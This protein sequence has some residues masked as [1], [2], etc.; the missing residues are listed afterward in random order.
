MLKKHPKSRTDLSYLIQLSDRWQFQS[1]ESK[2]NRIKSAGKRFLGIPFKIV[3]NLLNSAHNKELFLIELLLINIDVFVEIAESVNELNYW[4]TDEEL[5]ELK[6][7]MKD[8]VES[9]KSF[10]KPKKV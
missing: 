6:E 7:K 8:L 2:V 3:D 5:E 10:I 4:K 9:T 1:K